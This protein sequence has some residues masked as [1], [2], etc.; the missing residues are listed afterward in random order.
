[1]NVDIIETL[2]GADEEGILR[3]G[4]AD[5]CLVIDWKDGPEEILDA[6][7]EFLPDGYLDATPEED[8]SWT[9][10]AGGRPA[11]KVLFTYDGQEPFLAGLNEVLAPDFEMRQFRPCDGDGYSLL[12]RP[13][14]WWIQADKQHPDLM[15]QYFLTTR[16]LLEHSS[17]SSSKGFFARL[18]GKS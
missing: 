11:A 16:R 1:M 14:S 15:E 17:K 5:I 4:E 6:L 18:F 3:L 10:S 7:Q 13:A 2:L 8:G 12:V 9:V